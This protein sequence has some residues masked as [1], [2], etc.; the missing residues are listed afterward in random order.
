MLTDVSEHFWY[1]RVSRRVV[2]GIHLW[3]RIGDDVPDDAGH[4]LAA[5]LLPEK[6]QN[7]ITMWQLVVFLP[8]GSTPQA[9]V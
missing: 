9:T 3:D 2:E 4:A 6:L 5:D 1:Q 7:D 8:L